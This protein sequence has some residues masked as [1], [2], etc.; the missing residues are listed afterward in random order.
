MLHFQREKF[1]RKSGYT[2]QGYSSGEKGILT[3][4]EARLYLKL[5]SDGRWSPSRMWQAITA[6]LC[7]ALK[8]I[9]QQKH[10][11][12]LSSGPSC[13]FRITLIRGNPHRNVAIC[14]SA[15]EKLFLLLSSGKGVSQ[16][17]CQLLLL[18]CSPRELPNRNSTP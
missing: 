6:E 11:F 16:Q 7:S 15:S 18:L 4:W 17:R 2:C 12:L 10:P 9:S 1:V 5:G 3:C 13:Y 8:G 14:S